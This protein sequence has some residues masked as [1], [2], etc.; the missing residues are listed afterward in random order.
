MNPQE[1]TCQEKSEHLEYEI[2]MLFETGMALLSGKYEDSKLLKNALIESFAIHVRGLRSFFYGG[3]QN[4]DDILVQDFLPPGTIWANQG[5]KEADLQAFADLI[6]RVNKEIAHLTSFRIGKSLEAKQWEVGPIISDM[7]RL[8]ESFL[9]LNPKVSERLR[10][11][12]MS[13]SSAPVTSPQAQGHIGIGTS[14][15]AH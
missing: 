14:L 6:K 7:R 3:N 4:N 12:L 11:K 5:I 15:P 13:L 2:D 8:F 10:T 9:Q 1:P